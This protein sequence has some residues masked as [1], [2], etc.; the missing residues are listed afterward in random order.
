MSR[1]VKI[2][3]HEW[4]SVHQR[5]NKDFISV[6]QLIQFIGY[7]YESRYQLFNKKE[8][9]GSKYLELCLA[10]GKRFEGKCI[11]LI[12]ER[13]SER[14][15][16]VRLS[17]GV[18]MVSGPVVG[19]PDCFVV[20]R[21]TGQ[22][23]ILE[24]KCPFGTQYGRFDI[25]ELDP[26]WEEKEK[27]WKHWIQLQLY[28]LLWGPSAEF[29]LLAYFYPSANEGRGVCFLSRME[30]DPSLAET[31]NLE[32][33]LESYFND[34]CKREVV[35]RERKPTNLKINREYILSR[36]PIQRCSLLE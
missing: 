13:L 2:T 12:E 16:L 10:H 30:R 9:E 6:T 17:E 24:V 34:Y 14:Y 4:L 27:N 29:G 36:G 35:K 11:A 19:T 21:E 18:C 33:Q 15:E 28:L 1:L 8:G 5:K 7:G 31:L 32:Y 23:G 20:D 3:T 25:E 26:A 22:W